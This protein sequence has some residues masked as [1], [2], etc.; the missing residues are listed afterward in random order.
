LKT[1]CLGLLLIL[2]CGISQAQNSVSLENKALRYFV[3]ELLYSKI[4]EPKRYLEI[5]GFLSDVELLPLLSKELYED[6]LYTG[7]RIYVS[8]YIDGMTMPYDSIEELETLS[9]LEAAYKDQRNLDLPKKKLRVPKNFT[10]LP[11]KEFVELRDGEKELY[12]FVNRALKS[13][14]SYFVE[15]VVYSFAT[16]E[17]RFYIKYDNK[18]NIIHWWIQSA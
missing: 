7:F 2:P 6:G 15:L 12:L 10:V 1:L 9:G 8:G 14:T 5:D 17:A 3:E 13:G 11:F 4:D 18:K 16:G